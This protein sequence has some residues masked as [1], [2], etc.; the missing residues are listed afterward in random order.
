M[1]FF[2]VTFVPQP[3]V[4]LLSVHNQCE[5]LHTILY[6][7]FTLSPDYEFNIYEHPVTTSHFSMKRVPVNDIIIEKNVCNEYPYNDQNFVIELL[8]SG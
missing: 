5:H 2:Y 8:V 7:P 3:L 4:L 6:R 1:C